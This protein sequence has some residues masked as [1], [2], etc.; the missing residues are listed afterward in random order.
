MS[1]TGDF[2]KYFSIQLEGEILSISTTNSFLDY[3]KEQNSTDPGFS[4]QFECLSD[5][6]ASLTILFQIEEANNYDP[7]FSQSAYNIKIPTPLPNNFAITYFMRDERIFAQDFDLYGNLLNFEL[8][9]SE[10][11]RI[12]SSVDRNGI[13]PLHKLE[14]ITKQNVLRIG[15][16]EMIIQLKA[17]VRNFLIICTLF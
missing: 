4:I 11:F 7:E 8:I 15:G 16:N 2:V 3:E 17:T 6:T 1:L 14:I 9:G 13:K 5:S 12:E 10:N